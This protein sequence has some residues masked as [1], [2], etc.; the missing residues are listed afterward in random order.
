MDSLSNTISEDMDIF[1]QVIRS[2]QELSQHRIKCNECIYVLC[3]HGIHMN[4]DLK[5]L[6]D[7]AN[8]TESQILILPQEIASIVSD[9]VGNIQT[10]ETLETVKK[11]E[12]QQSTQDK[13]SIAASIITAIKSGNILLQDADHIG[14]PLATG[15]DLNVYDALAY[16]EKSS[17][18]PTEDLS[19]L[20]VK[21]VKHIGAMLSLRDALEAEQAYKQHKTGCEKCTAAE[22]TSCQIAVDL[23]SKAEINRKLALEDQDSEL[24]Y[25]KYKRLQEIVKNRELE[26]I[27]SFIANTSNPDQESVTSESVKN[28]VQYTADVPTDMVKVVEENIKLKEQNAQLLKDNSGLRE[29]AVIFRELIFASR[30]MFMQ[31]YSLPLSEIGAR[32]NAASEAADK[33]IADDLKLKF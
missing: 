26:R 29:Q 11:S 10:L 15:E 21:Y 22:Y 12:D 18:V 6:L 14:W 5:E 1:K 20:T 19:E 25:S 9:P 17:L 7:R 32:F 4:E 28:V 8:N 31:I 2:I 13:N 24:V 30:E 27:E 3:S 33:V 23:F 16:L